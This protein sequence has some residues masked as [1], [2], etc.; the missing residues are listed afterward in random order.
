MEY[1]GVFV[2][3]CAKKKVPIIRENMISHLMVKLACERR[4][5]MEIMNAVINT[6]DYEP[7]LVD[8]QKG[9]ILR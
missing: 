1:V 9:F 8:G 5:A 6:S 7:G 2:N 4:K 3:Q